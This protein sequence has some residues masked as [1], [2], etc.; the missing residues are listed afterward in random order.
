[1]V[2]FERSEKEPSQ[3]KRSLKP[4]EG[5]ECSVNCA[6]AYSCHED[7]MGR[8]AIFW[9]GLAVIMLVVAGLAFY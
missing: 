8:K 2:S 6:Y 9:P 4:C 7:R 1:M 3:G 5:P